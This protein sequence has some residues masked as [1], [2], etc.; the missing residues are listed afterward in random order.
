MTEKR[1]KLSDEETL[2]K[3]MGLANKD[4]V[5]GFE[6]GLMYFLRKEIY[7]HYKDIEHIG[8]DIAELSA[9]HDIVVPTFNDLFVEVD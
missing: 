2:K 4:Q 3:L 7:R 9:V 5:I 1:I 6:I 8:A